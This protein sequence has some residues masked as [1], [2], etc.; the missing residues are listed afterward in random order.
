MLEERR[1]VADERAIQ[2]MLVDDH[3]VLRAGTRRIL[4]DHA[5][6]R[7][8]GEASDG[9]EALD[10][11]ERCAPDVLLLDIGL[12]GL[13]GVETCRAV[14]RQWPS[15]KVLIL[16]GYESEALVRKLYRLGAEGYL[17]KSADARQL[18]SALRHVAQGRRDYDGVA[19]ALARQTVNDSERPSR[20]QVEVLSLVARGLKNR[21]IA[22]VMDVSVNTVEFHL[23]NAYTK[24]GAT[25]RADALVRAYHQGWL[26]RQEP[27]C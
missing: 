26:D 2:V 27:L 5:D 6:I 18:V 15:V 4:E 22:E 19:Q 8:V 14:R 25:S 7:V 10:M 11:I 1:G 21:D 9:N 23:R 24:L 12:P 17:L 20:K 3:A 16:T 13:G